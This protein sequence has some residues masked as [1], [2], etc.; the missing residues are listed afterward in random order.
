MRLCHIFLIGN[1][2]ED[3]HRLLVWCSLN[4]PDYLPFPCSYHQNALSEHLLDNCLC[5]FPFLITQKKGNGCQYCKIIFVAS[6]K[7]LIYVKNKNLGNKYN[8]SIEPV[9]IQ[10]P[11]ISEKQLPVSQDVPFGYN[12]SK[13]LE[14]IP[15]FINHLIT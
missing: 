3:N 13:K 11:Q 12:S 2:A 6:T 7:N 8:K 10:L 5:L 15:S 4:Y 1:H 9:L 14:K